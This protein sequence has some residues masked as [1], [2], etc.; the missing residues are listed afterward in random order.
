MEEQGGYR[1][2]HGCAF[3][4]GEERDFLEVFLAKLRTASDQEG[5]RAR[6][7]GIPIIRTSRS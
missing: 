3:E 5:G 1:Q 4:V 6:H 2:V 7:S